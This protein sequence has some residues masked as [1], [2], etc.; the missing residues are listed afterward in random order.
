MSQKKVLIITYYWPPAGGPGVQRVV[1]FVKYLAQQNWQ[2]LILTVKNPSAP[3][4]DASLL[5][6]IPSNCKVYK[7][8]VFEPFGLYRFFTGKKGHAVIPKDIIVK[9]KD[10]SPAERFSRWIRANI[11]IPDAR[12]GWIPF[13][14]KKGMQIIREQQPVCIFS[15]SPPHSLQ[16]GA[17]ILARKSGLKW[18]ADFRDPWEENYWES[19]IGKSSR[20]KSVNRRMEQAVLQQADAITTVSPG[21]AEAFLKKGARRTGVLYNGYDQ[22]NHD[23]ARADR[24]RIIFIGN[25]SKYQNPAPFIKAIGQLPAAIRTN[26]DIRFIGKVFDDYRDMLQ[27]AGIVLM[28]YMP[29]DRLTAYCKTASLLLLIF[30][31]TSYSADY[32]TAKMFDYLALRKPILAIGLKNSIGEKVLDETVSG[33]LFCETETGEIASYIK[34]KYTEWQKGDPLLL[35]SNKQLEYYSSA[36]NVDRLIKLFES[37]D[38]S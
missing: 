23:A 25:L 28:D 9:K 3:A 17:R 4:T 5:Q 34:A 1:K 6:Q 18:I 8:S 12:V 22:L 15:T 11:F 14:V 21:L 24:F 7:T 19:E 32:I 2:P 35:P 16:V 29:L 20:S 31:K 38:E 30:H 36:A 33:K 10:D 26:L 13:L 37:L 27:S